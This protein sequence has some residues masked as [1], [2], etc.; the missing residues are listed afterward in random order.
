MASSAT[1]DYSIE[2][3][4]RRTK[5]QGATR[6]DSSVQ[7]TLTSRFLASRRAP[8]IEHSV[9]RES[10]CA[11]AALVGVRSRDVIDVK[12]PIRSDV[13]VPL[14]A[15]RRARARGAD[16]GAMSRVLVLFG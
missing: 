11:C 3:K 4:S 6:E 10:W 7:H 2:R 16:R 15:T 12:R 5:M 9:S 8:S 14:P 1:I 13:E